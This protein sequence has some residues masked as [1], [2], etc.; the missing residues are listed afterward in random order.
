MEKF[1][2]PNGVRFLFGSTGSSYSNLALCHFGARK[3]PSDE[4]AVKCRCKAF[5]W[6]REKVAETHH[7]N[8]EKAT[9]LSL[10]PSSP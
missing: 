5:D 10:P 4:G 2:K 7:F 3:A 6:G 9:F 1:N 8:L